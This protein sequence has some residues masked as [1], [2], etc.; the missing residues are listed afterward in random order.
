VHPHQFPST[1]ETTKKAMRREQN[2][3]QHLRK[4]KPKKNSALTAS[5]ASKIK[6]N[7]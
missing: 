7:K 1:K 2:P 3:K 4:K 5:R 6:Y